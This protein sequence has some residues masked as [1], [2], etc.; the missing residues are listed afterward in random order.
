M[1][2][3]TILIQEPELT[4]QN[5]G[6]TY[7]YCRVSN[8]NRKSQLEQQIKRCENFCIA[9]GWQ[10]E[11]SFKEVA[12]GMNDQRKELWKLLKLNPK[13][14]VIENKDRL[15]RFGFNYIKEL[16]TNTEIIIINNSTEDKDDLIKDLISIITSFCGKI[17]SIRKKNKK[18][19]K[20]KEIIV[21]D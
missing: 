2:T 13:R 3:G 18:L 21:N 15:T 17:Y 6:K 5:D 11:K 4:K 1:D 7:I 19:S 8:H 16:M 10:I 9:N 12:S 20:I 14:I